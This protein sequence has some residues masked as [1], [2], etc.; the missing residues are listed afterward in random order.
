LPAPRLVIRSM[1]VLITAIAVLF[2]A[3]EALAGNWT[4]VRTD[5]NRVECKSPYLAIAGQYTCTR[6]DGTEVAIPSALVDQKATAAASRPPEVKSKSVSQPAA[7]SQ[8]AA[9]ESAYQD[10]RRLQS[11]LQARQF[12]T[13]TAL[14][15]ARQAA[16]E[17]DFRLETTM[18]DSF[19]PLVPMQI[20]GAAL[21]DEWVRQMP[22]SWVPYI[23]RG[24]YFENQGWRNRGAK[25]ASETSG[26]QVESMMD[27][28]A[29]ASRD[30]ETALRLNRQ[31]V[32]AYQQLISMAKAGSD[33]HNR[34]MEFL[35]QALAVCPRCLEVRRQYMVWLEPRWGG[36]HAAMQ[37]FA[38]ESQASANP[39]LQ[40]LLGS[41]YW[42]QGNLAR[43]EKNYESAVRLYTQAL[44]AGEY[45]AFY[46]DRGLAL[47]NLKR[48][49][50]AQ[51]DL[52]RA[53]ALRPGKADPYIARAICWVNFGNHAAA[54]HD[55]EVAHVLATRYEY[56][57]SV[58][59]WFR[60][61]SGGVR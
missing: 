28:F 50:E 22:Q 44:A 26:T 33:K 39:H 3:S 58:D 29:H 43:S 34:S 18:V 47:S 4:I 48:Y 21:L 7:A 20:D 27:S 32:V 14:L 25:W 11:L 42:D 46:Y 59:K 8:P 49:R 56:L 51:A 38:E 23:A 35:K 13:L 60:S 2:V 37:R 61:L 12:E 57:Q 10:V 53:I 19:D 54:K 40:I 55:L 31:L 36:S 41:S 1:H 6:M 52:D 17:A 45:W 15:E 30:F 24:F 5:G 9:S 16:F